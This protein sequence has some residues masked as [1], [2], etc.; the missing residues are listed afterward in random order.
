MSVN[1]GW[2]S[3]VNSTYQQNK[4]KQSTRVR[5]R[6]E[7]LTHEYPLSLLY[8]SCRVGALRRDLEFLITRE[9]VNNLWEK[10]QGKCYY[11][12]IPM[13]QTWNKKHPQQVSIDRLDNTKG[14]S[15]ENTVLCCQSINYAKNS[16]PLDIFLD[17]LNK[18]KKH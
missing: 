11:S 7:K 10:Q 3:N 15:I 17:F 9:D 13:N 1:I 5:R 14:Y 4:N 6:R 12:H 8:S 18:L 2:I 16:Y